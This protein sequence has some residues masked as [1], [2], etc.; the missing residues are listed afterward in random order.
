MNWN[1]AHWTLNKSLVKD[2]KKNTWI[3]R[4]DDGSTKSI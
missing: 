4:V 3:K 1:T 2:G